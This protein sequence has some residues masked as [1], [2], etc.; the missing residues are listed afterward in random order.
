MYIM[1]V[2]SYPGKRN[3][4]IKQHVLNNNLNFGSIELTF[5]KELDRST[6]PCCVNAALNIG[7]YIF[8]HILFHLLKRW[9]ENHSN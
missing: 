6:I 9:D 7:K 5:S 8:I 1:A 4:Q 2:V 3:T